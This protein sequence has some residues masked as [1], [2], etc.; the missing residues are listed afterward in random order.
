MID[1]PN[2]TSERFPDDMEDL[3]KAAIE[4]ALDA[5]GA[6]EGDL[7]LCEGA[8]GGDL[9]FARAALDLKLQLE[10]RLPF[11]EPTFLQRSVIFAGPKWRTRYFDVKAQIGPSRVLIMPVELGPT[12]ANRNDYERANLWQLYSA[13]AWGPQNVRVIALWNREKSSK[14]GGTDHMIEVVEKRSGQ[15]EI[16]DTRDLLRQVLARRASSNLP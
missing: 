5:F 16:I 2:R 8:C 7:A 1:A 3:A 4:K 10:L 9:L 13:L 12:P 11:D 15:Y 14:L 6:Q